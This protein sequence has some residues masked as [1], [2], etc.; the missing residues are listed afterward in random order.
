MIIRLNTSNGPEDFEVETSDFREGVKE[1]KRDFPKEYAAATSITTV[2][3]S[4]IQ[5]DRKSAELKNRCRA[6][7]KEI[8]E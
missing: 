6:I 8:W 1:V 3:D 2:S 7:E 5:R 4:E